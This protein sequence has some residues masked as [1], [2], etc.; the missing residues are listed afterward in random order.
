M[1]TSTYRP[2]ILIV[3]AFALAL[4]AAPAQTAPP[5]EPFTDDPDAVVIVF[6]DTTITKAEFDR[7]FELAARS[8]AIGQ[9]LSVDDEV[10]AE[11]EP[12]KPGFLEQYATQRILAAEAQA[13]GLAATDEDVTAVVAELRAEQPDGDAFQAWLDTAGYEDETT[14]RDALAVNLSVQAVVDDL[15]T[16]IDVS[17]ADVQA[18]YETNPEAVTMEDGELVPLEAVEDQIAQLLVQEA[19]EREVQA[20][21]LAA[22]LELHP[23][24]R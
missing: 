13:R 5:S 2:L 19:V 8:T 21:T 7:A 17:A 23:Q 10:L 9:G 24:G 1:H 12:F 14:L 3:A 15:A 4:G 11:F 16:D 20:I 18:W 22:G 6:G